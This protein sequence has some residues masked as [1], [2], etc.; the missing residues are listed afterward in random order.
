MAAVA[1]GDNPLYQQ[2]ANDL[3]AAIR[4]LELAPGDQVP[5]EMDLAQRYGVSRNTARMALN[6]LAHEGLI[7]AGRARAGRLVRRRERMNWTHRV[8]RGPRSGH[9]VTGLDDFIDQSL[10]Q[11]RVPEQSIEVSIVA[12]TEYIAERLEVPPG[13]NLV[14]RRRL[15]SVD[16]QPSSISES[17][18]LFEFA[19]GTPLLDPQ[20][21]NGSATEVLAEMGHLQV[22]YVDE[23]TTRMPD[24][25]E[26]QRLD[27]GQGVPVLAHV[28]TGY[29]DKRPVR[30]SITILPGDRHKLRYE[31]PD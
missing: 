16:G 19:H 12:A 2:I 6:A 3:R 7:T 8:E 4:D 17:Y 1:G 30:L 21:F 11:G 14:V 22:R 5:T 25:L 20:V 18:Y 28:R 26:A 24:P 15:R 29:T 27:I 9:R 23:I 13:E 10:A 31:L